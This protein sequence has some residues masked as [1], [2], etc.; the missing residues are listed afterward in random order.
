[1]LHERTVD[2]EALVNGVRSGDLTS[3]GILFE[4]YHVGLYLHALQLLGSRLEAEDAV[5]ETFMIALQKLDQI[6]HPAAVGGWLYRVLRNVC[7]M[8]LRLGQRELLYDEWLPSATWSLVEDTVEENISHLALRDWVWT[9]L[10][11]LPDTLRVTALLRYFSR[12]T[13]YS[14]IATV[15]GVPVGTVRSRLN[16]VKVKLTEALLEAATQADPCTNA[17]TCN[18]QYA[19]AFEQMNQRIGC[20]EYMATFAK[21]LRLVLSNGQIADYRAWAEGCEDMLRVG[22]KFHLTNV[23]VSGD[24]LV[25][26]GNLE[27]PPEAP[28]HCPPATTQVHFQQNGLTYQMRPLHYALQREEIVHYRVKEASK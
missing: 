5:Q 2:D 27:N 15:L 19:V 14:A 16:Q 10:N 11:Q 25:L 3:L 21:S 8:R 23:M 20:E 7:W 13:T 9:A 4:C 28:F 18:L 1:M 12:P 6:S 26:E 17:H 24:I 22:V